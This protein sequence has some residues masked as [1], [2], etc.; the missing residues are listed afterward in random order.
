MAPWLRAS[1]AASA[2]MER[3]QRGVGNVRLSKAV[4][5]LHVGAPKSHS[6]SHQW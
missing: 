5:T 1:A 3:R 2:L 6:K 4:D